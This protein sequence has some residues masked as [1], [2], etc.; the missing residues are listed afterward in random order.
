MLD[1]HK[2]TSC[3]V[4]SLVTPLWTLTCIHY[5]HVRQSHINYIGEDLKSVKYA[6]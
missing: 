2:E 1:L 5:G 3:P 6:A 4:C